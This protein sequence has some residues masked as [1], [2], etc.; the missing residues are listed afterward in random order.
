MEY[1]LI[2]LIGSKLTNNHSSSPQLRTSTYNFM[3]Y[4]R[5]CVNLFVPA[6][7]TYVHMYF[8]GWGKAKASPW[9]TTPIRPL[10][11][12]YVVPI[13]II[14][15]AQHEALYKRQNNPAC[16]KDMDY[17]ESFDCVFIGFSNNGYSKGMYIQN[18][19]TAFSGPIPS[20]FLWYYLH[21]T[22]SQR[23]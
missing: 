3:L 14:Y 16:Y 22:N 1:P 8:R 7:S 20:C 4:C 18:R 23:I 10:I 6:P 19:R 2:P 13:N 17:G 12:I 15:M 21:V 5:F 9:D 11:Q